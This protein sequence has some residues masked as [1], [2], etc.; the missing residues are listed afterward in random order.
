MMQS[1]CNGFLASWGGLD[2][3]EDF[4]SGFEPH[5][6]IPMLLKPKKI[7]LIYLNIYIYTNIAHSAYHNKRNSCLIFFSLLLH[8]LLLL[9]SFLCTSCCAVFKFSFFSSYFFFIIIIIFY[10][11]L[12]VSTFSQLL[13][14][15]G[16]A[17]NLY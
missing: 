11:V 7:H 4:N 13:T 15:C 1:R 9:C 17:N 6:A 12:C 2:W 5:V 8:Y 16:R 10:K 14:R 3:F